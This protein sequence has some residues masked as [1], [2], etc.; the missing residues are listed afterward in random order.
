MPSRV[1]IHF[2]CLTEVLVELPMGLSLSQRSDLLGH[3]GQICLDRGSNGQIWS[4]RKFWS[5]AP[6]LPV[7]HYKYSFPLFLT[8]NSNRT[9][10]LTSSDSSKEYRKLSLLPLSLP[11]LCAPF[12]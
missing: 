4:D 2:R 10:F 8:G 3:N 6:E 9:L 7:P 1:R 12:K 5:Q 11:K